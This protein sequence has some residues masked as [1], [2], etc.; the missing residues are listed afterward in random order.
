M[1]RRIQ[2]R[3]IERPSK[4]SKSRVPR[5]EVCNGGFH[6]FFSN[7]T[8][9]LA[10]EAVEAYRAIGIPEWAEIVAEA[11]QFFGEPYPRERFD[12]ELPERTYGEDR[13]E[14]DP[15]YALDERFYDWTRD[16]GDWCH[17][18]DGYASKFIT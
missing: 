6:Q 8:G 7:S 4:T 16:G 1:R 9:V 11:M 13:E 17:V 15:F 2:K 3:S 12:R 5:T 18:A 14:W 10:P